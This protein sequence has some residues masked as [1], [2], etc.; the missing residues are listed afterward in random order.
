MLGKTLC[1]SKVSLGSTNTTPEMLK[2]DMK[3]DKWNKKTK[4]KEEK[5]KRNMSKTLK[6]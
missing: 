2:I 5:K 3:K 4:E 6:T 1:L